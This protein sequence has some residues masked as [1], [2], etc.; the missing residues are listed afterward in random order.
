MLTISG[1]RINKLIMKNVLWSINCDKFADKI[2]I[3]KQRD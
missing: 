1:W 2:V 3:N